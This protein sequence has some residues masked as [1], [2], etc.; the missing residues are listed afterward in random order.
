MK[1]SNLKL[2]D[3]EERLRTTKAFAG[4]AGKYQVM[5]CDEHRLNWVLEMNPARYAQYVYNLELRNLDEPG[6]FINVDGVPTHMDKIL[7]DIGGVTWEIAN[8]CFEIGR[9]DRYS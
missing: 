6:A 4:E 8:G 3:F 2:K 7:L 9:D 1:F 5:S